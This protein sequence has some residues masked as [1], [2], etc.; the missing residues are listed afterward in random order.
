[1]TVNMELP[2]NI[3]STLRK[4]RQLM[5]TT[6]K[7]IYNARHGVKQFIQGPR[8]EMQ[9][10]MKCLVE[11]KYL[12]SH[13]VLPGTE[14]I[15]DIFWAHPDSVKLFN[16]FPI[17]LIMGWIYKINKYRLPLLE[18]VGST[19]TEKTYAVAFAFMSSEKEDNFF[20]ALQSVRNLLQCQDNLK[21]IVTDR[22]QTRMKV[23]DT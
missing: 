9:H 22:N 14:M 13:R 5:A 15:S 3:M 18:F 10:L 6:I 2:R 7:H 1:M 11:G 20:W 12:Y 4:R 23:V 8:T 17:V 21:V 16:M 19:S